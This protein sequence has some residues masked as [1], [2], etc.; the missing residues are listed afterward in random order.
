[1][2]EYNLSM[3]DRV[4]M[5]AQLFEAVVH[6]EKNHITHRDI[7]PDNVLIKFE[8]M[9]VSGDGDAQNQR[10]FP[11]VYLTDFGCSIDKLR[12]HNGPRYAYG[13]YCMSYSF[14]THGGI[15]VVNFTHMAR[16]AKP[17]KF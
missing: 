7:K 8:K 5:A 10:H 13:P 11:R 15:H 3:E 6:L 2:R 1:M 14:S 9:P 17:I 4:M 16:V 12:F